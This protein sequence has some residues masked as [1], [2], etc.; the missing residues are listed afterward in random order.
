MESC[1]SY[2]Q[3]STPSVGFRGLPAVGLPG[4]QRYRMSLIARLPSNGASHLEGL[5]ARIPARSARSNG[6]AAKPVASI[7]PASVPEAS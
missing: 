5:A 2:A 7:G 6:L 4:Q 1:P 3:L